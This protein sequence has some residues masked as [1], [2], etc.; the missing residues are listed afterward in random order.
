MPRR[1]VVL[2]GVR[3]GRERSIGG[4]SVIRIRCNSMCAEEF[5]SA[6]RIEPDQDIDGSAERKKWD[7]TIVKT[8]NVPSLQLDSDYTLHAS[9]VQSSTSSSPR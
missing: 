5:C 1:R 7:F 9:K 8:S 3:W 2:V 4:C 6:T